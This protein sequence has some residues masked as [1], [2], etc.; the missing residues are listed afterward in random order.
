MR[1]LRLHLQGF[2]SFRDKTT[3]YFDDGITGIV[4]PNGCGKSNIVDAL[5]WVMGEQSAK[6]LRGNSMKDLIFAGSDKYSPSSF[7][8]V[9]LVLSND[10][11]KHIHIGGQ[12][13]K[14]TEIQI[15]RKLYRNG[16]TEYRINGLPAR[17]KDIQE[18]FMDTGAGAKSYSI[19]AQGEINRLVQAKPVERRTMIEE[20]AGITK[21]KKRKVESLRKMDNTQQN[22]NRLNDLQSEIYKNLKALERQAEKAE[23]ARSLKEKIKKYDLL[24]ESHKEFNFLKDFSEGKDFIAKNQALLSELIIDKEKLELTLQDERIQKSVLTEE[25]DSLQKE[26]N[27]I[28]RELAGL[29]QKLNYS[30]KNKNEKET[31]L[32]S[33]EEDISELRSDLMVLEHKKKDLEAH[34]EEIKSEQS[35]N[36]ELKELETQLQ[37]LRENTKNKEQAYLTLKEQVENHRDELNLIEQEQFRVTSR[38]EEISSNLEDISKEM[39][40][41][42][43]QSSLFSGDL[44]RQK[45]EL[46]ASEKTFTELKEKENNLKEQIDTLSVK[47]KELRIQVKEV[48]QDFLKKDSKLQSLKEINSNLE[49]TKEGAFEYLD[50]TQDQNTQFLSNLIECE[51]KYEKAIESLVQSYSHSLITAE[52][53]NESFLNWFQEKGETNLDYFRVSK[54]EALTEESLERLS[55]N[56]LEGIIKINDIINIKD[57]KYTSSIQSLFEG[58][59]IVENLDLTLAMKIS[60][61]LRFKALVSVTGDLTVKRVNNSLQVSL[62]KKAD[63]EQGIIQR[64]NE[65]KILEVEVEELRTQLRDVEAEL[66]EVENSLTAAKESYGK[67]R[68]SFNNAQT[69]YITKKSA[70]ES[71]QSNFESSHA[72]IEILQNRKT[73]LSSSRLE[74][75]EKDDKNKKVLSN[76]NT[77]ITDKKEQLESVKTEYET[78][79]AELEEK[80]QAFVDMEVQSRTFET[81]LESVNNQIKESE[82]NREKSEKKLEQAIE[83]TSTLRE[84]IELLESEIDEL[85]E[86][87]QEQAQEVKQREEEL[88][89]KKNELNSL[90]DGMHGRESEV[91][92]ISSKIN[93]IEKELFEREVKV[94]QIVEEEELVVRNIFEKY[95]IDLRAVLSEFLELGPETI[96]DL[97]DISNAFVMETE[98]GPQAIQKNSYQFD[99]RYGAALRECKD[100]FRQYKAE[101]NRLGEINWQ[102]IEDYNKQKLRYDFLKEQELELKKSLTD[103]ETAIRHID[104]KSKVRFKEAF[105]EVNDKFTKIFPIIFGGGASKLEITGSLDDAECGIDIIAQPP[106]KKMQNINLMSGGEKAMTAVSLIF[107]IF[108]VKPSPFCLLDEVDAPLDDA[109]VGRFNELLREMSSESQFI[110]ITHNKKT[111]EL[112]DKLYGVTMQEPG[113]SKALSV[114]LQ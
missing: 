42:E 61:E 14:P 23:R 32:S 63:L 98:E 66:N 109:N 74:L 101:F 19:I 112:N 113:I 102:A 33:K 82:E 50:E 44:A 24:V 105:T 21:F 60:P 34:L 52:K 30:K 8:E 27:E 20:V 73:E 10:N 57:P 11:G 7:A 93:K 49:K 78:L 114:Q 22:L 9:S 6:H 99:R 88:S 84:E 45:K 1:L 40:L 108:L 54:A 94:K 75:M 12:V 51:Q 81:R 67:T 62:R 91:K 106:G 55:V 5:F 18:V 85:S 58:F 103:L 53:S 69:D 92:D 37:E 2:K 111:M 104:D 107:S 28:S 86:N 68:D 79:K 71:K 41:L 39:E 90:L 95:Q 77:I 3:I 110:L 48:N 26:F 38:L 97:N 13:A 17:L 4:G 29:E 36:S 15:T 31:Y 70:L 16:E 76:S 83:Q 89:M 80:K 47:E 65:I 64:N 35:D 25:V 59:L 46:E 43:E 96:N 87:N 56:G 72:R 100:K